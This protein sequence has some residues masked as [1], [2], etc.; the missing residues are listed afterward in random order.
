MSD[1]DNELRGALFKNDKKADERDPDYTGNAQVKG[2][3]YFL[4]AWLKK[5]KAGKTFMSVRL[6]PKGK[7][8][9]D[10]DPAPDNGDRDDIPF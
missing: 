9:A 7:R 10:V 6:K 8:Q 2:Q 3:E 4:D 5:S 1:Y